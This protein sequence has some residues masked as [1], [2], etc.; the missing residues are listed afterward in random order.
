MPPGL[1]LELIGLAVL[2]AL[3]AFFSASETALFSLP[4]ARVQRL[5]ETGGPTGRAIAHLL[6]MPRRLLITV[7]VGNMVVNTAAASI[8]AARMTQQF[9]DRGIALA[10]AIT[11]SILLI[12]G[13][14]TPKTLAVRHAE[15]VARGVAVPL[16]WFSTL[17]LPIRCVLRFLTNALLDLLSRGHIQSEGLLTRHEF[18]AAIEVGEAAGVIDE[19]ERDMVKRIFEVPSVAARELLVPRTE[20]VCVSEDTTIADA[21]ALSHRT[22][23]SRLPVYGQSI[24]DVWG[25]FDIRELPTWR[26]RDIWKLTIR[27]FVQRRDALP[28]PPPRPLVRPAFVVPETR[29]VGD[30]LRDMREGGSHMAILLDEYGGTSGLVTLRDLIDE[31]VGGVLTPE[32]G[33]PPLCRKGEGCLQVLGDARLRDLNGELGLELPL[34]K[35]DTIGGYVL[36]L[37]GELPKPGTEVSD[38]QFHYRVLRLIGR[39]IGAV[40]IRPLDPHGDL[41][42]R[43]WS[44][45]CAPASDEGGSS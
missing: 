43:V 13:E 12:F 5:G 45:P 16:L 32:P 14:V 22:H 28:K 25:V 30:L 41:W 10:I 4:R 1:L 23:H 20:M 8:I 2:F 24:D 31:L 17:I 35:A 21:L 11:T 37:V 42:R 29:R 19:H 7:L 27:E 33:A 3:S 15:T 34:D 18:A 44:G 39:R 36:D 6:S 40:E 9:G 26:G 38:A